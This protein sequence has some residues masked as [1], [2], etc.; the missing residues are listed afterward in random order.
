MILNIEKF[1]RQRSPEWNEFEEM[2]RSLESGADASLDLKKARRYHYLYERTAADLSK[3]DAYAGEPQTKRYLE[4][5][6]ARGFGE[7][8]GGQVRNLPFSGVLTFLLYG[9]PVTVRLHMRVLVLVFIIFGAGLIFGG[10]ALA[11]DS[12]AKAVLMP[13]AHLLGD[14][15]DRVA[16]EESTKGVQMQGA[17]SNFSAQL[18]THNTKVAILTL[19]LG[20][21]FGI[22]TGVFLFYNGAILGAVIMDYILAGESQF[23]TA[24]L[25]PHGGVEIPAILLAGQGGLL[26]GST[27]LF[28]KNRMSL[29][30]RLRSV[31]SDLVT[32][33]SGVAIMLVW[34]GIIESFLSQYHEPIISYEAKIIFGLIQLFGIIGYFTFM[35]R[36]R[37]VTRSE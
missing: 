34:A 22:G 4:S 27:L 8:H 16:N 5:L 20:M 7:M 2:V 23:L 14:P 15:G 35:G 10:A 9:F 32:L 17:K 3:L 12:S 30:E 18:M 19:A 6:I 33:I 29:A 21:T 13:F 37:K 28:S 11:F 31:R 26:L 25:L 1:I 24:W 36:K